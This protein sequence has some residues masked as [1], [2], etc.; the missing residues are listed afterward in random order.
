MSDE[1]AFEMLTRLHEDAVLHGERVQFAE[2]VSALAD[3]Q[4]ELYQQSTHFYLSWRLEDALA[5]SPHDILPLARELAAQ[6]GRDID[7][8]NRSLRTLAYHGHL[9]ALVEAMRVAW[10][11]VQSSSNVVPWGIAEF[12]GMGADYEIYNYLQ[13]TPSPDPRDRG[14][15]DRIRFFIADPD[16]DKLA[17]HIG[18]LAGQAASAWTLDDFALRPVRKQLRDDWDDEKDEG[19]ESPD[20][21]ARN[22]SRLISQFVGYLRRDEGVPYPKGELIRDEFLRYFIR[23]HEGDLDP[24]LSML[25]QAMHPG[26][27]L[28]PPPKPS[29]SLCPE[30]VTFEVYLARLVGFMNGRYHTATALFE[31]VPAWLRFLETRGLIDVDRHAK[32]VEGLRPLHTDL[33]RLLESYH[34]DPAL[35]HALQ[36]WPA[37]PE[38]ATVMVGRQV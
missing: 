1:M 14:L 7:I 16:L 19:E 27:K 32:T 23:R 34:D 5:E 10:P 22:L 3:R 29:H 4:P 25:E 38:E 9:A 12:G 17:E 26:K 35:L 31:L 24:K 30:R 37:R 21:G 8:V 28:P 2:L 33:L 11:F 36:T 18:D 6:A 13:H 15:L 20:P